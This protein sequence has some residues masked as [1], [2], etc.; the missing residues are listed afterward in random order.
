MQI[1]KL[2]GRE[3]LVAL[4]H[5]AEVRAVVI[6]YLRHLVFEYERENKDVQQQQHYQCDCAVIYKRFL[7]GLVFFYAH[8]DA[9]FKIYNSFIMGII[10]VFHFKKKTAHG[11]KCEICVYY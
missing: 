2:G 5:R 7:W 9:P 10:T 8:G 11:Y 4:E 3:H 1:S 6:A